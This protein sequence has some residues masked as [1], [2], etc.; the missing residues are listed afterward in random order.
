MLGRVNPQVT[1]GTPIPPCGN[2]FKQR[3]T[4]TALRCCFSHVHAQVDGAGGGGGATCPAHPL[5][6]GALPPPSA[7]SNSSEETFSP[8]PLAPLFCVFGGTF[9]TKN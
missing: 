1:Q 2:A 3:G 7:P 4:A 9:L 5:E 6:R 8:A